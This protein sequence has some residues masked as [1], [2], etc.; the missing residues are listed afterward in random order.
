MVTSLPLG[1]NGTLD[2][3]PVNDFFDCVSLSPQVSSACVL[4]RL[5]RYQQYI[6]D[7]WRGVV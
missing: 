6:G 7:K 3:V 2:M 5:Y 1:N 4:M